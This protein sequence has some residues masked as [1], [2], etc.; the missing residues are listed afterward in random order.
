M[1]L[2]VFLNFAK[3]SNRNKKERVTE[4]SN[5]IRDALA[6]AQA[7]KAERD[8]EKTRTSPTN[9]AKPA[10]AELQPVTETARDR[11]R[12]VT[13][14]VA[15][16]TS[17]RQKI[18]D[19]N[20]LLDNPD[21]VREFANVVRE[22]DALA[23]YKLSLD[24]SSQQTHASERDAEEAWFEMS[25]ENQEAH[26]VKWPEATSLLE[27]FNFWK[28]QEKNAFAQDSLCNVVSRFD[29]PLRHV[30]AFGGLKFFLDDAVEEGLVSK[31]TR[32]DPNRKSEFG[33]YIPGQDDRGPVLY[34]P[35]KG[36]KLANAGW[37][38]AKEAETRALKTQSSLDE[39]RAKET[40]GITPVKISNGMPGSMFVQL[41]VSQAVLLEF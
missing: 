11:W 22:L 36:L 4:M 25:W 26:W 16:A 19:S 34:L 20:S 28:D 7:K 10:K 30:N 37:V 3:K 29:R 1:E 2:W 8:N 18:G 12:R 24:T 14:D 39:L 5:S 27:A 9:G 6:Q 15:S 35:K 33:V 13:K 40:P 32:P 21:D 38:F 17:L 31:V 41:G 23:I